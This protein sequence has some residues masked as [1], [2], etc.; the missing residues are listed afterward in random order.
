MDVTLYG[1]HDDLALAL[2]I[3]V[4]LGLDIRE[5]MRHSLF[6]DAR[7]FDDLRQEHF[8]GTEQVADNIHAVHQWAFDD[9]DRAATGLFDGQTRL[10]SVVNDMGVDPFDQCMF[11]PL[12]NRPTA[13]FGLG[14]FLRHIGAAVFFGQRDQPLGRIGITVENDI[15]AGNTKLGVN[16][17]I[18]VE[19]AGIDNRHVQSGRD[20][21]VEKDR[22]HCPADRLVTPE[23]EG[24][25]RK[26]ARIMGVRT[27]DPQLFD[28]FDEVDPVIIMLFDTGGDS[29]DIGVENDVLGRKAG[30]DQ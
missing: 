28:C 21:V 15:F 1:R 2:G 22:M 16:I 9:L 14:F 20:R 26:T 3:L 23:G 4:L 18:N 30:A 29:K 5:K 13:P 6:H 10:F 7:R 12:C 27:Q 19:L 25:V 24:K 8:A 11:E 17:I